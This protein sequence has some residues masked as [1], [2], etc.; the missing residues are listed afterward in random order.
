MLVQVA[1]AEVADTVV[2][3]MH[4][5][6]TEPNRKLTVRLVRSNKYVLVILS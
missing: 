1:S 4:Y 2:K 5:F 6:Y 3:E